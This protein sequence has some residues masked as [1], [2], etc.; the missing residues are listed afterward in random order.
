MA[1]KDKIL[2]LPWQI[3]REFTVIIFDFFL[4]KNAR[5]RLIETTKKF[6]KTNY[7]SIAR[8]IKLQIEITSLIQPIQLSTILAFDAK[9]EH[10]RLNRLNV[11]ALIV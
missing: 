2:N 5:K 1:N 8:D 9:T 10:F 4:N 7:L 11:Y 3:G 6:N